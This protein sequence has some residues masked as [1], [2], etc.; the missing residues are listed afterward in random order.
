MKREFYSL[1]F[2]PVIFFLCIISSITHAQDSLWSKTFGGT[3]I[4]VAYSVEETADEGYIISG[5][6]RSYGT[7]SGR[8]LWLFKTDKAG[9][10]IWNKTFGGNSDDEG[11]AAKQTLDGGFITAGHTSSFGSGAKDVFVV[12]TDSSGNEIWSRVFGG[13]SDEEAYGLEVLPDGG[14]MIACATSSATAGSRDGWLIRLTS[15]GNILWDKKF[16]GL[17]TDG[18]RGIQRTTDGGFILTGWTASD[19][20]GILGNAWLVKTDS[21]GNILFNKNF[22]GSD[23]DRGLGVQQTSDGGYILAGYTTSTGAGLD[24][25][26]VIKTDASG[27]QTWIKT[28]GG[29]GRDYGNAVKQTADG[30]YL[31]AG[32]TLSYG[33]GGDDLWLVKIDTSGTLLWQ[34]TFGGTAS[35]VAYSMDLTTDGGYVI[36]G[37]TLSSG[38]GVHDAWLLRTVS[39]VVPVELVSFSA[40]AV[41]DEVILNWVTASE[42]NNSGFEIH[43]STDRISF[44]TVGFI[45]GKGTTT[46]KQY[47]TF[48]DVNPVTENSYYRLNQIDHDGSSS[49]SDVIEV[50]RLQP[51]NYQ[52]SQNHPNPFNPS[53]VIRFTIPETV[54]AELKVYN[55]NGEVIKMLVKG[56]VQAGEHRVTFDAGGLPSG[57]YIYRLEA[58]G[59]TLSGKM[60][61]I[62]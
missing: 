38:A 42:V 33:A 40:E 41:G 27:N 49:L 39:T 5:Y 8:N 28:F 16:G 14:Y 55:S 32:Y 13:T 62:K 50:G 43:R 2:L 31:I 17:S 26:Y 23:A 21:A 48:S 15:A 37:H 6:T 1:Q 44:E 36:A 56:Q 3:N 57:M 11:A 12:R 47:Y 52:L 59:R 4:D 22:G 58:N 54:Y 30:A 61:L 45:A 35:D 18:F 20:A 24:D 9:N 53:T 51:L 46:E 10:L 25:M 29:T 7:A 60:I 19:G 34:K